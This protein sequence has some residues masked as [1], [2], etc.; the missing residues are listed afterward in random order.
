MCL[1][2]IDDGSGY[3]KKGVLD[4]KKNKLLCI[5]FVIGLLY[6]VYSFVYWGSATDTQDAGEAIGAGIAMVLVFPHLVC[7]LIAV[8]FN[9]LGWLLHKRGFALTAGIL[10]AVAIALFPMYF[11]FVLIEMILCFI[12]FSQLKKASSMQPSGV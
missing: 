10:Y 3:S 4:M 8:I 11:F 1:L 6:L 7:T 9:G 12:G 2:E 5:G